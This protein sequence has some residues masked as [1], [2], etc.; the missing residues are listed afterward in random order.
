VHNRRKALVWVSEGYDF[1]PF[2]EARLGLKDPNS[3]FLQND[4]NAMRNGIQN[5]DGT[6]SQQSDPFVDQQKQ[7]ETFSDA[8]LAYELAEITRAANRANTTIYTIDPR[9]LI[10]GS[11]IDE[12]VDPTE[13][14]AYVR[15]SQDSMR[16]LAEDTGGLAV[17]NQNDFDKALKQIDAASSD[18]YVL[19]YYSTNPDPTKRRRQVD[20]K[21]TR[22]GL[23]VFSRKEYVIKPPKQSAPAATSKSTTKK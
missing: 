10:A 9:G 17:V 14:N 15:K 13:W 20:V 12:Q 4:S 5:Q 6:T 11:D 1:N 8:D 16:V 23:D 7:N 3:P 18:Y 21:V 2:Q 19:G 22:K